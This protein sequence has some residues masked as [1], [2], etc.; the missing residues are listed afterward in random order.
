MGIPEA[1]LRRQLSHACAATLVRLR[2]VELMPEGSN[3]ALICSGWKGASLDARRRATCPVVMDVRLLRDV[4]NFETADDGCRD[5]AGEDVGGLS[6]THGSTLLAAEAPWICDEHERVGEVERTT[7][8]EIGHP[9]STSD[10]TPPHSSSRAV[11]WLRCEAG[12]A[13]QGPRFMPREGFN[14]IALEAFRL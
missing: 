13:W 10:A 6:T 4:W 2:P 3:C 1:D 9:D 8:S 11:D 14:N 12:I 7:H 5:R